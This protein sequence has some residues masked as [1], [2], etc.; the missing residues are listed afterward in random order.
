MSDGLI[1]VRRSSPIFAVNFGFGRAM[2]EG[3]GVNQT[4][5]WIKT[6]GRRLVHFSDKPT[7]RPSDSIQVDARFKLLEL[8]RTQSGKLLKVG[9]L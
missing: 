9:D 4:D 7:I 8:H 2:L 5:T 3:S 6:P 1:L